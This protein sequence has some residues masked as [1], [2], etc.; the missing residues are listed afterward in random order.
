MTVA[1]FKIEG[2]G[3]TG[4]FLLDGLVTG[5]EV[6]ALT[7]VIERHLRGLDVLIV[8]GDGITAAEPSAMTA[9]A[10]LRAGCR[11]QGVA[12]VVRRPSPALLSALDH[13]DLGEHLCAG[14]G[15]GR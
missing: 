5:V 1:R 7:A 15:P 13:E 11:P 2:D 3:R 12:F 14:L 10:V 6:R 9:L 4:R 8:E